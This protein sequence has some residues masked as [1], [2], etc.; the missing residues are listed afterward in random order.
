MRFQNPVFFN[1]HTRYV[2]RTVSPFQLRQQI[3]EFATF[4][5]LTEENGIA[6]PI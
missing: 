5:G 6:A 1:R 3:T 4:A 2:P